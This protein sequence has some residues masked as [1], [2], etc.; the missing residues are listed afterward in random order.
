MADA[1]AIAYGLRV[2]EESKRG[3]FTQTLL[4]DISIACDLLEPLDG[5]CDEAHRI[6]CHLRLTNVFVRLLAAPA[7]VSRP[8]FRMVCSVSE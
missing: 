7:Q 5:V 6:L 2:L 1:I 3:P 4:V 8:M